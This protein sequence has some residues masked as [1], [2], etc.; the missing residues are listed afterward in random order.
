MLPSSSHEN[1]QAEIWV[2]LRLMSP[3]ARQQCRPAM[4]IGCQAELAKA[5]IPKY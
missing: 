2:K 1:H 5:K 4:Q 3:L